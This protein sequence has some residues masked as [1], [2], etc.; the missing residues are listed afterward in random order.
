MQNRV[1]NVTMDKSNKSALA[2]FPETEIWLLLRTI[3][4]PVVEPQN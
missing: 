2:H 1:M 3:N 4:T